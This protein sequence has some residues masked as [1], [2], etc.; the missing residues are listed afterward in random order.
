MGGMKN[1][2]YNKF[3]FSKF[4]LFSLFI[5]THFGVSVFRRGVYTK[6]ILRESLM[7]KTLETPTSCSNIRTFDYLLVTGAYE[8]GVL[9]FFWI[10]MGS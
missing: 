9:G 2:C 5:L 3:F 10:V 7:A 1:L 4:P 6:I 8:W